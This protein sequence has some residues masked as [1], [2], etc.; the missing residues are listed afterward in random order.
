MPPE[1]RGLRRGLPS[2]ELRSGCGGRA[3]GRRGGWRARGAGLLRR[4]PVAVRAEG[5]RAEAFP[6]GLQGGR[7]RGRGDAMCVC[8]SQGPRGRRRLL[9]LSRRAGV[10]V[11]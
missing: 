11:P 4:R 6:G 7:H 1:G 8:T 3:V 9:W 5:V 2:A 10:D